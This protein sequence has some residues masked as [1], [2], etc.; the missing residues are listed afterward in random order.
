MRFEPKGRSDFRRTQF[1]RP[2][3]FQ[4]TEV[5][6]IRGSKGFSSYG[7]PYHSILGLATGLVIAE[8]KIATETT[9]DA[10]MSD[11]HG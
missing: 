11:H 8:I 9:V 1:L 7:N 4:P 6:S 2:I 3:E 10:P 5:G